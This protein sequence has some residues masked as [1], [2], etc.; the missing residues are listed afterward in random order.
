MIRITAKIDGFRRGG[1]AHAKTPVEYA[2]DKFTAKQL[3]TLQ[4]ETMLTVEVIEDKKGK[5]KD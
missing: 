2:D 5:T 1:I 3:Q 4:A